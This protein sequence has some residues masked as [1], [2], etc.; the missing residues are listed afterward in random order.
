[1]LSK[2][3]NTRLR[4]TRKT[5]LISIVIVVLFAG[6]S[7]FAF[8]Q[9]RS[10]NPE[11]AEGDTQPM[12]DEESYVNYGPPTEE[13][14]RAGDDQKQRLTEQEDSQPPDTATVVIADAGQYGNNIEVR[15]FVT[16]V[17]RDG[18]CTITFAQGSHSFRR[19]TE[20]FADASTS[21]CK[22]MQIPRSDFP[23]GGAW[24]V[25]VRYQSANI[26]GQAQKQ[27]EIR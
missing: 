10:S 24:T 26:S 20:A 9:F 6:G 23:S 7:V 27:M 15:A 5:L 12:L 14:Q 4:L 22:A 13:E 2:I 19:Q 3:K 8:T 1:M 18:T 17:I 25:T 16:N 21:L 11:Q